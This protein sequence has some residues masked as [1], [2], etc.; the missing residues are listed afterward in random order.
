MNWRNAAGKHTQQIKFL[1]PKGET[2]QIME[3]KFEGNGPQ[4]SVLPVAGTWIQAKELTGR[5][6]VQVY[7]DGQ[8][9]TQSGFIFHR[10]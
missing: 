1:L 5:W 9:V 8:L 6:T 2:Y 10:N 3:T 4:S 7:L